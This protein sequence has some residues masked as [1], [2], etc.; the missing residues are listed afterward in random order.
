MRLA[1]SLAQL[2]IRVEW[3]RLKNLSAFGLGFLGLA[4]SK[5]WAN[6]SAPF[7]QT[8]FVKIVPIQKGEKFSQMQCPKND[9]EKKGNKVYSIC[10]SG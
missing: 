5:I 8:I 9:L 7:L 2:F 4:Q 1:A 3:A 6:G 10:I